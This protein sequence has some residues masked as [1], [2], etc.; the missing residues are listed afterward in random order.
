MWSA[1][2]SAAAHHLPGRLQT[3][4]HALEAAAVDGA[5][6]FRR[7]W[8]VTIPMLTRTLFFMLITSLIGAFQVFT[9]R[10]SAAAAAAAPANRSSSICSTSGTKLFPQWPSRLLARRWGWVLIIVAS[11]AIL[12]PLRTADRWVDYET[13][14][15]KA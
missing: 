13:E 12:I 5:G 14:P 3:Q 6:P 11:I 4:S 7:F 2:G 15:D 8:D 10:S 1:V 9:P